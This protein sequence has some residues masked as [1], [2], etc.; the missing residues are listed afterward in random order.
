MAFE[1][2][3]GFGIKI[4]R[5]IV[6]RTIGHVDHGETTLTTAIAPSAMDYSTD[7]IG[8]EMQTPVLFA[9]IGAEAATVIHATTQLAGTKSR[10]GKVKR[11]HA[12]ERSQK[13]AAARVEN[14]RRREVA[15][16]NNHLQKLIAKGKFL[17]LWHHAPPNKQRTSYS[18]GICQSRNQSHPSPTSLRPN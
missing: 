3:S 13:A 2:L 10:R 4:M 16:A 15:V 8:T 12:P 6:Y 14:I 17:Y 18:R 1:R 11:V 7:K 5:R 9:Q